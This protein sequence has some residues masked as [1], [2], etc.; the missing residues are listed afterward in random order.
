MCF[1]M[2]IFEMLPKLSLLNSQ[3]NTEPTSYNQEG[4]GCQKQVSHAALMAP[5]RSEGSSPHAASAEGKAQ[6][7][8]R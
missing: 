2:V 4:T 7:E 6:R 8:G 3:R 1:L 5:P